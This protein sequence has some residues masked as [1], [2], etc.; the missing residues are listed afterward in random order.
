MTETQDS[1]FDVIQRPPKIYLDTNHLINVADVRKGKKLPPGQS[2]DCYRSLDDCIRSYCGLIFNPYAALEWVEGNASIRRAREIAAVVDSAQ[3]KYLID[4]DYLVYTTEIIELCR[5][6]DTGLRAPDLPPVLQN[7]S[8]N[9]DFRSALGILVHNIPNY[10]EKQKLE[11]LQRKGELPITVPIFSAGEWTEDTFRWKQSNEEI[12]Q[13]RR[14][15]FGDSLSKDIESKEEYFNNS[16]R[17]R[18]DWLKRFLKID[19]ILRASNP[20][21]D[22]DDI[23]GKIDVSQCPAVNL[24]WAVREKR[25][26]S[27][28]PPQDSD[29]D[30]YGYIPVIPYADIVLV[31]R[32]LCGFILQADKSFESKVFSRVS[33]AL[34]ALQHRGFIW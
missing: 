22:I 5:N 6:I 18:I 20:G 12:Y 26:K 31:E 15:G 10:I 2:E 1:K 32:Q 27:A 4:A 23:L 9:S 17:Y 29:V 34:N 11:Q 8:D 16:K 21:I 14:K 13:E 3:V 28:H 7:I 25:M 24:C 33:D 19:M 30:D